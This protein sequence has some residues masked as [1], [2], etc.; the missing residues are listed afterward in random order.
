MAEDFRFGIGIEAEVSNKED[1][2]KALQ[3][4][5]QEMEQVGKGVKIDVS[6]QEIDKAKLQ[7]QALERTIKDVENSG[8]DFKA[9]FERNLKAVQK[10]FN[11]TTRTVDRTTKSLKEMNRA[12]GDG[13]G[14]SNISKTARIATREI[15]GTTDQIDSLKQN[16]QQGIG[17]TL[18]FGAINGI[19]DAIAGSVRNV[20]EL[21]TVMTDIS[22]VA[23]QTAGEMREYRDYAGEAADALGTMGKS[24]LEAALIYEQQGGVAATYAK[25]L[26]DATVIA[27]N[28]SR[29]STSQ[30]SEYLTATINGFDLLRTHGGDAATYITDVM[31]KLGAA[32]GSDLG[33]IATGLTRTANIA[34]DAGFEFEEASAMIATVS[35]VTR[36][37]PETIGNAFRSI[38]TNFT[39]L[40]EASDDEVNQFTGKIEES[41][42]MAGI[43]DI[44]MFDNGNLRDARDIFA[45]I[46]D[47][48]AD[49]NTEQQAITAEAV[50]GKY[51]AETFR[52]FM[53]N[54]ERYVDL[55]DESYNAAGT[56]AQQQIIYMDSIEAKTNQF[57]NQWEVISSN[58]VN[59]D[60]FKGLIEDATNLLKIIGA[61]EEGLATLATLA[62]PVVGIFGQTIGARM[63]GEAAQRSE[64][65]KLNAQRVKYA[66]QLNDEGTRSSK[67]LADQL[68]K[69]TEL[70]NIM[71]NLGKEAAGN[72]EDLIKEAETLDTK[73]K[74]LSM[75]DAEFAAQAD[76]MAEQLIKSGGVSSLNQEDRVRI[77]ARTDEKNKSSL[78]N[79][80]DDIRRQQELS[81]IASE[82]NKKIQNR[83]DLLLNVKNLEEI[84]KNLSEGTRTELAAS[85][86][87][88]K[89]WAT[90]DADGY[91][92]GEDAR[93]AYED[94]RV[95][96]E[97]IVEAVRKENKEL[98][99]TIKKRKELNEEISKQNFQ[100]ST[101]E[102]I[103]DRREGEKADL[104]DM[105]KTRDLN[106][107][108]QNDMAK[109]ANKTKLV[110]QATEGL[111]AA[112]GIL[113]PLMATTKAV[114]EE[115]ISVQDG[116]ISALQATSATVMAM[117]G[118][119]TKAFAGAMLGVS[120]LIDKFDLFK[121][122]AEKAKEVND[123]LV[124]SFM[125]LQESASGAL[126]SIQGI[127]D[128]YTRF[129]GVDAS[130]FLANPDIDD[131]DLKDYL[132][133]SEKLAEIRPDLVKYYDDEGRAIVDLTSAY[134]DLVDA[135]KQEVTNASGM[136]EAGRQSFMTEYS[137]TLENAQD[138]LNDFNLELAE[139]KK[140]LNEAQASGVS[141]DID[142]A[143]TD[144]MKA[145]NNM[146]EQQKL[147]KDTQD[148]IN[149]NIVNPFMRAN[150]V[151]D[152][153]NKKSSDMGDILKDFSSGFMNQG[154]LSSLIADGD[155]EKVDNLT[156]NLENIYRLY[157]EIRDASSE[158]DANAFLVGIEQSSERAKLA[159][160]EN[161]SSIE[162]LLNTMEEKDQSVLTT[163]VG[164]QIDNL[165]E[166]QKQ[167]VKELEK[168]EKEYEK[169]LEKARRGAKNLDSRFNIT[170]S[171]IEASAANATSESFIKAEQQTLEY[172]NV[173][174]DLRTEFQ[175]TSKS[176]K[177]FNENLEIVTRNK[178]SADILSNIS[179][180]ANKLGVSI[181]NTPSFSQL[182]EVSPEL[183]SD[184]QNG[185]Y[186]AE[187]AITIMR[188]SYEAATLGMMMDN[189]KFFTEWRKQNSDRITQ[190]EEF[191]G[192][193]ASNAKTLAEYKTLLETASTAQLRILAEQKLKDSQESDILIA[194]SSAQ[195]F[196]NLTNQSDIW[197]NNTLT[198]WEKVV[199]TMYN[200][201]DSVL[202][203]GRTIRAKFDE[204][205]SGFT[206]PII[207]GA[208]K[209]LDFLGVE[210][211]LAD[212]ISSNNPYKVESSTKADDYLAER[213]KA[214]EDERKAREKYINQILSGGTMSTFELAN[215][216]G[217]MTPLD[218]PK[219]PDRSDPDGK[220]GDE[221]EKENKE[222]EK[223]IQNLQL[224][225]DQYYKIENQ[226]KKLQ[227][228]YDALSKKRD[229][230]YGEER[231]KLM[232][233]E[234]DMLARQTALLKQHSAALTQEQQD[235]RRHLGGYG[236][237]FDKQGEIRNLNERL[238]ALQNEANRQSGVAK[239][240]AIEAV[241]SLQEEAS[242]YSTLT[243]DLIPDKK[244]AIEEAKAT[245][246]QIAREKVEYGVTLK[247][248]RYDLQ[249]E[250]LDV[251]SDMQEGFDKLDERM[252]NTSDS[253]Q[254][255]LNQITTIQKAMQEVQRNPGLTDADRN[256]MMQKY[257]RDLLSA[258]GQA[259]SSYKE[260]E[261]IQKEFVSESINQLKEVSA[262]YDR[263]ID[264]SNT[265]I[266]QLQ[267]LYGANNSNQIISLYDTQNKAIEAQ[268]GHLE[269]ARTQ[270][271]RYRDTL[272]QGSD[273]WKEAN[274]QVNELSKNIESN[275]IKQMDILQQKFQTFSDGLFNNFNKMFGVWGFDGAVEDFD[276]LI[277]KSDQFLDTYERITIIGSK[278]KEVNDEIA[279]TTDPNRIRE[280][281]KYRD[282]EL[283]AL[284][285]QDKIS[286]AEFERAEKLYEIKLKELALEQ[287]EDAR[288]VA[289]LVRDSDG[290]MSYEYVRQETEE[291]KDDM[292]ELNDLRNDLYEFDS[293]KVREAARGIFEII[294]SYQNKLQE[295]ANRGLSPEEYKKAA[296][297]L[298]AQTQ[299]EIDLQQ[300]IVNKWMQ[301]VGKD[302]FNNIIELFKQDV[303]SA[304]DLGFDPETFRS[305]IEALEDGSLT[306]QDILIGNYDS[307]ASSIGVTSESIS[308]SM[309]DMMKVVLGEN[310]IITDELT[311]ASNKWTSTAQQNVS[312]LGQAYR[313]YMT[314]ADNVLKKYNTSTKTL[315]G[316]LNQTNASSKKVTD[317]IKKQTSA[318]IE[319]K[320]RTDNTSTSV[321]NLE[322]MLIGSG[323]GGLF[324]S[325]VKIKNEQNSKLQP[326]L[327]TTKKQVDNMKTSVNLA[328]GQ[329]RYMGERA[330]AAR[331]RV[332]AYSD[333]KTK[334]GVTDI[335]SAGTAAKNNAKQYDS[336]RSSINRTN[337][338]VNDLRNSLGKLPGMS[339]FMGN[340]AAGASVTGAAKKFYNSGT[341]AGAVMYDTGGYTGTW[342]NS[343]NNSEGR[344]AML[345]EKELVLNKADTV[346]ILEAVKIQ[347]NLVDKIN[348]SNFASRT[349]I[350]KVNESVTNRSESH[351]ISQP[352]TI[353]AEF[354]NVVNRSEIE[355]AFTNLQ[356]QASTYIGKK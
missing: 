127:E 345:H 208:S 40:R 3:Q 192:I 257:Q 104:E 338:S 99:E 184:L 89:E 148:L 260:M 158:E 111:S 124:R 252:K 266:T 8:G 79:N 150:G 329:Y 205:W 335:K 162:E 264:K 352:V 101:K 254:V 130:G 308:K 249:R 22:I 1:A 196:T 331:Q 52:A 231:L 191:L 223:K 120:Y 34:R 137:A 317:S 259:R 128:I 122:A 261:D 18:A 66:E 28:V 152:E 71:R 291:S 245:F 239:E 77:Q 235:I 74:E 97:K 25:D 33:E 83:A 232:G 253:T 14:F 169:N 290:N 334:Q 73:I 354:P 70:N 319:T 258:V 250:I 69:S 247:V 50:A 315:D 224:T 38:I 209:L 139:A 344:L 278:I 220:D 93:E 251:I 268:I 241:K 42:K 222:D 272:K 46:S 289:Q 88:L 138:K 327:Q 53:N 221:T 301:N 44:S 76:Q 110:Q 56:A 228:E 72:F 61:Q 292:K 277:D 98:S 134:S 47:R 297:K 233:Q 173:L 219:I 30:M 342:E 203:F 161:N 343:A 140:E 174:E 91:L 133:L 168:A 295:L 330:E 180:E 275:L 263:I 96:A 20:I 13:G 165:R 24:Y 172:A 238:T 15:Q 78:L 182:L 200:A 21:D 187:E 123:E 26:A 214:A 306:Y 201:L 294:Q 348:A 115:Q 105:I 68:T 179:E 116:V 19:S 112:Y 207:E 307:F 281:T 171:D 176:A 353:H 81:N 65:N 45:D 321:K 211:S 210:N 39:Q 151:L 177:G 229:A 356:G 178:E 304:E 195:K 246:S 279:R 276:K 255:S 75:S 337:T 244:K 175:E 225:L 265:M 11:D 267:R 48:W 217:L 341:S 296:D 163:V 5:R 328:G 16:L 286:K 87:H 256:A 41:F 206:N 129:E 144:M 218:L 94:S 159:L 90:V 282:E 215:N 300:S 190:S 283:T 340:V 57:R 332:I 166:A 95:E 126:S 117:P 318:M 185:I 108:V 49:M 237:Q 143:L 164:R 92:I 316:L 270:L 320:N 31:A 160:L 135:Q 2:I 216:S 145:R 202:N 32:S 147:I 183:A 236:F 59:S 199:A 156:N 347:R 132:E 84:T 355:L 243:F 27:A 333:K 114:Q 271:T 303:V 311:Q 305:I 262:E 226:L 193:D 170:E 86:E 85:I 167:S 118:L 7:I 351:T 288:R 10:D 309:Q 6:E 349:T 63:V 107:E 153:M 314:E 62:A 157:D 186:T 55:L 310:K 154:N 35:E 287:R 54:Q 230:A 119:W 102:Y 194:E 273:A 142:Q 313:R 181:E 269:K 43:S 51:Q 227:N 136:L 82:L 67:N 298:L 23:G 100:D 80:E 240:A 299:K 9:S 248:D 60:M 213:A 37:T 103:M 113:V 125:S 234:Q 17:Q 326:S 4:L 36:R 197:S 285:E 109:A 302:G 274:D 141:S 146:D 188:D 204:I 198:T 336:W 106:I 322:R 325:M 29:E 189:E 12:A 350:N 346:N 121:S 324:G 58:L 131:E 155:T 312:E 293:G 339:R 242:R 149:V 64:L 323:N 212:D 280:L 284:L